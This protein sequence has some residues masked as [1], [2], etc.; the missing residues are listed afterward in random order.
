MSK[1]IFVF[2][3]NVLISAH[4]LPSS[5]SRKAYEKALNIGLL[6]RSPL[7]FLEFSTRFL[8]PKFERYVSFE[9][10]L[11]LITNFKQNSLNIGTIA[12]IQVCRDSKDDKYLDLALATN[13]SAIITGDKDLLVLHPFKEIPIISPADF[14]SIF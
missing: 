13:A 9:N 4:L 12:S 8:R 10:R 7:T 6:V 3:C 11:V 14:L 5:T 2:D 1:P